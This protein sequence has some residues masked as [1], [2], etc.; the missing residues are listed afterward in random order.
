MKRV[1]DRDAIEQFVSGLFRTDRST[2][3]RA[4]RAHF[5][6]TYRDE[7]EDYIFSRINLA[8]GSYSTHRWAKKVRKLLGQNQRGPKGYAYNSQTGSLDSLYS[9]PYRSFRFTNAHEHSLT[10]VVD[11]RF[12]VLAGYVVAFVG[13]GVVLWLG[14]AL[15]V[16]V[17]EFGA[18]WVLKIEAL[19]NESP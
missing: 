3:V 12:A 16:A 5:I 13:V 19:V 18:Q 15:K 10:F 9:A 8:G 4:Y 2:A 1:V 11:H 7:I 6:A 14:Y 17:E